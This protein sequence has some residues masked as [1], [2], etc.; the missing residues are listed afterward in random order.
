MTRAQEADRKVMMFLTEAGIII[1]VPAAVPALVVLSAVLLAWV[2][3]G[4]QRS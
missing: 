1:G 4:F 2:R 3:Q